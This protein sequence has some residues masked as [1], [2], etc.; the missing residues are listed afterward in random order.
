V[1]CSGCPQDNDENVTVVDAEEQ[2]EQGQPQNETSS[3][4]QTVGQQ[5]EQGEEHKQH[6]NGAEAQQQQPEDAAPEVSLPAQSP[7]STAA[8]CSM[9]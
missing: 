9:G 4:L 2:E 8:T 1:D 5:I 7:F 6:D 3:I